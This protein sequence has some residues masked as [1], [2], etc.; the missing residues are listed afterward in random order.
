[1]KTAECGLC[2]LVLLRS[3]TDAVVVTTDISLAI[4]EVVLSFPS[5]LL[6]YPDILGRNLLLFQILLLGF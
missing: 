4:F 3:G 1:M 2:V 5:P 6:F